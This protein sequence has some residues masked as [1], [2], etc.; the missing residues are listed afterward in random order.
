MKKSLV[1]GS[2]MHIL[3]EQLSE[4]NILAIF[5]YG[6]TVYGTTNENSDYDF[7]VVCKNGYGEDLIQS[8]IKI[9]IEGIGFDF[10]IY[11]IDR[12]NELKN[13][14][15][16]AILECLSLDPSKRIVSMIDS[17]CEFHDIHLP[18][19]R[20]SISSIVNNSW[21]KCKKKLTVEENQEY[22][23]KK[24]LFHSFRI[25]DFGIQ[26]ARHG[27]IIDFMSSSELFAE[28]VNGPDDWEYYKDKYKK[29]HNALM[30][31]FRSLAPK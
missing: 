16:I 9:T 2:A 23:G 12:F 4:D 30:S 18:T 17:M 1:I 5:P 15:D 28:I 31:E 13:A 8:D 22:I 29:P 6:S 26:I 25:L 21:V 7:I 24:S 14:H 19:L 3:I 11:S 20:K 10:N 27:R